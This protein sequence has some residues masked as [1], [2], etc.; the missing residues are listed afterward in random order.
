MACQDLRKRE[1]DM[2]KGLEIF[3][4]LPEKYDELVQVEKKNENLSDL[5][6]IKQEWED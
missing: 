5:W 2:I 3:D 1:E 6:A 4:I